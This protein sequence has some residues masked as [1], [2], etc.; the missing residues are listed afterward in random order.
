[1]K[2]KVKFFN[3]AKGFGFIAGEDDKEYFV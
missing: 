3:R 2:G 1:M